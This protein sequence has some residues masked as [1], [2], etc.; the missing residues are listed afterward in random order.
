MTLVNGRARVIIAPSSNRLQVYLLQVAQSSH[1]LLRWDNT[2][3]TGGFI[4]AC[5]L[6]S[7]SLLH[8]LL[9]LRFYLWKL[10]F[11]VSRR[12]WI[13]SV[14]LSR[15]KKLNLLLKFYWLYTNQPFLLKSKGLLKRLVFERLFWVFV[16]LYFRQ[17]K[18]TIRSIFYGC[19][20]FHDFIQFGLSHQSSANNVHT[21]RLILVHA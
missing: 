10:C 4:G 1:L 11:P 6:E 19:L 14:C 16:H 7:L 12:R 2:I 9:F 13:K 15:H 18:S 20:Q 5:R 8:L 17:S 3:A 21:H